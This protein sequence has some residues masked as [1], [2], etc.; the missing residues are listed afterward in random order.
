M[1]SRY[2]IRFKDDVTTNQLYI[3][4]SDKLRILETLRGVM[5]YHN[6]IKADVCNKYID[7]LYATLKPLNP[8]LL[9]QA[10]ECWYTEI[11][12]IIIKEDEAEN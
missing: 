5:N 8:D 1:I 7:S 4:I 3:V 12:P 6:G 11:L 10:I 9:P 2:H